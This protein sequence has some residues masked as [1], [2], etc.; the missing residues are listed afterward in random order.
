MIFIPAIDLKDN[1]CVRL[2][3]GKEEDIT[4][5]NDDPVEQAKIFEKSGCERIHIVDLDGAFGRD[6]INTKT[7]IEIRKKISIP[8]ELGGGIR[9]EKNIDFWLGEG[10]NFLVIGSLA[11][12][13]RDLILNISKKYKDKIYISL[14][15]LSDEV[16]IKGWVEKSKLKIDQILD[17]YNNSEIKGFIL[18]DISRDGMLQGL[19]IRLI[20][21]LLSKTKKKLIVGGGL[22]DYNDLHSLKKIKNLNL[23]GVIAGKSFYTGNIKINRALNILK[24]NA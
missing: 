16:M 18:T 7:I 11:I 8:I 5:F 17:L 24:T 15:V 19:D 6:C 9:S 2:K 22:S 10:I 14:D 4:V 12:K 1:K 13:E 23:E 3:K 21:K 20:K